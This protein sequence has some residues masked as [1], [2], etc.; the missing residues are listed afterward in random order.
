MKQDDIDNELNS[1]KAL[2]EAL[3]GKEALN[4]LD[5]KTQHVPAD[6]FNEFPNSVL[7]AI[8]SENSKT[9]II[10]FGTFSKIAIAAA[11]LLITATGYIFSDKILTNNNEIAIV[12][13]EEITNEEIEKYVESNEFFVEVDWQSEIDNASTELES[14]YILLKNDTN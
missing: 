4:M 1:D 14:N 8:R 3:L 6:Y 10:H 13:I 2:T 11:I 12:N 5:A 7:K 9:N